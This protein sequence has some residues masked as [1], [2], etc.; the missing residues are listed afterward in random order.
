MFQFTA[1]TEDMPEVETRAQTLQEA[2]YSA[3]YLWDNMNRDFRVFHWSATVKL[4]QK[5]NGVTT[6][7]EMVAEDVKQWKIES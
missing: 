3:L 5:D 2:V 1:A 6:K 4:V 7:F